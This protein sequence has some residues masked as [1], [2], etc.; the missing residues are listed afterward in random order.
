MSVRQQ[1]QMPE[2]LLDLWLLQDHGD[3]LQLAAAVRAV[4]ASCRSGART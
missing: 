2:S 4:L 3:E 1:F